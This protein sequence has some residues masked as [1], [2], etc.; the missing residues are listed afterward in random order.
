MII[1]S[2]PIDTRDARGGVRAHITV[3]S[4]VSQ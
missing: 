4:S 1:D 2:D 3:S